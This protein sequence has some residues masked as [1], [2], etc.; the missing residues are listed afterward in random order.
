MGDYDSFTLPS[1]RTLA[2]IVADEDTPISP[3]DYARIVEQLKYYF[4]KRGK[5][6][7]NN[8]FNT[9]IVFSHQDKNSTL[10]ISNVCTKV[11]VMKLFMIG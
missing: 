6:T 2:D 7:L 3:S 5:S 8:R 1:G 10:V 11:L 4:Y 9:D